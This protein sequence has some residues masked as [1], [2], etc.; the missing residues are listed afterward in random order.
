[1]AR[2]CRRCKRCG[3]LIGG[4]HKTQEAFNKWVDQKW[5]GV[6]EQPQNKRREKFLQSFG[7]YFPESWKPRLH[8]IGNN[9]NDEITIVQSK[10]EYPNNKEGEWSLKIHKEDFANFNNPKSFRKNLP[11]KT[12]S[13]LTTRGVSKI[14]EPERKE[15]E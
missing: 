1:M 15:G 13:L 12:F 5:D 9:K 4:V 8:I 6:L 14:E 11:E 7:L 10:G 2:C 3:L